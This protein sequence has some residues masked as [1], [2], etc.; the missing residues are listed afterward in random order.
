MVYKLRLP[1]AW[2]IHDVFHASLLTPQV[3]TSE[4]GVPATPPL[5]ELVDGEPEF[6]V[7]SILRHKYVG[8]KKELRYLVQ[9]R[10]YS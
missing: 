3:V 1:S 2:R 7:E 9:W 6:E 10:G 5:P 8:R 4:Y